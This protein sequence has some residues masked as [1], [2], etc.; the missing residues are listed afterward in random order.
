MVGAVGDH[1]EQ[2]HVGQ[3]AAVLEG[4]VADVHL[5]AGVAVAEG[6]EAIEVG[7]RDR[8]QVL[9]ALEGLGHH[10]V[11]LVVVVGADVVAQLH[12]SLMVLDEVVVGAGDD[13]VLNEVSAHLVLLL[14]GVLLVGV[15][16]LSTIFLVLHS[17]LGTLVGEVLLQG[18][19]RR[20]VEEVL[21]TQRVDDDV[22]RQGVESGKDAV[23]G[24]HEI[25]RAKGACA[26]VTGLQQ[27]AELRQGGAA[28]EGRV[29]DG[30]QQRH[31]R[32]GRLVGDVVE[33]DALQVLLVLEC[34]T[35]EGHRA[36]RR[37][38]VVVVVETGVDDG[39]GHIVGHRL[40]VRMIYQ[41]LLR[42]GDD[43]AAAHKSH[44]VDVREDVF[45]HTLLQ[46]VAVV[47][48]AAAPAVCRYDGGGGGGSRLGTQPSQA[49]QDGCRPCRLGRCQ[50]G[51]G[52]PEGI[53]GCFLGRFGGDNCLALL[54]GSF[55]QSLLQQVAYFGQLLGRHVLHY[56]FSGVP[57]RVLGDEAH[58]KQ[59]R[60]VFRCILGHQRQIIIDG[61]VV[62][63]INHRV[64][65]TLAHG[66]V[67]GVAQARQIIE[68]QLSRRQFAGSLLQPSLSD[69]QGVLSCRHG[70]GSLDGGID[71]LDLRQPQ[72][73]LDADARHRPPRHVLAYH[74]RRLRDAAQRGHIAVGQSALGKVL[75][76]TG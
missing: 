10:L 59:L 38:D 28:R 63:R 61:E 66:C 29:G 35:G 69:G 71:R 47:G 42:R 60:I 26:V 17:R 4:T 74:L 27:G 33:P 7:E 48:A 45:A 68:C 44:L 5:Q 40:D 25:L 37:V 9:V 2:G 67:Q 19:P 21:L 39:V 41:V 6:S 50:L 34:L 11:E 58:V 46:Q 72:Q 36:V 75:L 8:A 3:V 32:V 53:F 49:L 1:I 55:R 70:R 12:G 52:S 62:K 56:L 73:H 31:T 20:V 43:V 64:L 24:Q 54:N 15:G 65:H 51:G 76:R 13:G 30:E 14:D 57:Y 16:I 23:A 22:E 18:F